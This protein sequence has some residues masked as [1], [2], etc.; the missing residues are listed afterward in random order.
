MKSIMVRGC[1][2][3]RCKNAGG[4]GMLHLSASATE[5]S[6]PQGEEQ[7]TEQKQV[8]IGNVVGLMRS[9]QRMSEVLINCLDWDERRDSVP[10]EGSHHPPVVG[11]SIHRELEKVIF[12]EFWGAT[13]GLVIEA[14]LENM[15]MCIALRNYTSNM[16]VRMEI[17]QL[18]GSVIL[19]WKTFLPHLNMVVED[20]SWDFFEE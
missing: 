5:G 18:K 7:A 3:S 17:F 1:R 14:W 19:W 2:M 13:D 16:K 15:V 11:S 10:N 9:F 6:A 12:P 20:V 4:K 8:A